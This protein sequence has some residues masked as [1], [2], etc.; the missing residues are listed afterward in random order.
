MTFCSPG[1][2][3]DK[4]EGAASGFCQ[5]VTATGVVTDCNTGFTY[6][7]EDSRGAW[8]GRLQLSYKPGAPAL[9]Y[10]G[11]NRGNKGAAELIG[12]GPP[13]G[14]ESFKANLLQ[15]EELTAYETGFKTSWLNSRLRLNGDV[16]YYNYHNQQAFKTVG[17]FGSL[18]NAD[19]RTY[20]AEFELAARPFPH[21]TIDANLAY[22]HGTVKDVS[23]PDGTLA[24]QRPAFAPTISWNVTARQEVPTE[25][26]IFFGQAQVAYTGAH[27]F[28]TVN[29]PATHADGSALVEL[30]GGW[31]TG[32]ERT[33][34]DV[35][36]NNLTNKVYP[37]FE[38]NNAATGGFG[39]VN[40]APPR[41][42]Q[43]RLSQKF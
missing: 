15:P 26:G 19:A 31:M 33:T 16:F 28:S 43:V 39:M 23:L 3:L 7:G 11:V 34:L 32:D 24:D 41:W 10:T 18:F 5:D 42:I 8:S 25:V 12:T 1:G 35:S 29:E 38:Y 9:I 30:H 4:K 14:T 6:G 17:S 40:Y 37:I 22:L 13:N 21:T 20:G 27:Y 2:N 36:V